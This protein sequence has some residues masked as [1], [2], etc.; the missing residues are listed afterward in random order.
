MLS[1]AAARCSGAAASCIAAVVMMPV[2]SGFVRKRAS[3]GCARPLSKASGCTRPSTQRPYFGS[4]SRIV[5]PPAMIPPLRSLCPR[6]R[7]GWRRSSPAACPPG[8]QRRSARAD[9]AAHRVD[10]AHRVGGGDRAIVVRVVYQRREEVRRHHDR[11]L[12]VQAVDGGVV[13]R[14]EADQQVGR[15]W[16]RVPRGSAG[17]AL[18]LPR[19][20]YRLSRR[21]RRA[22]SNERAPW[23][24]VSFRPQ[25]NAEVRP[26]AV[27][28]I[29]LLVAAL[30]VACAA[31][32]GRGGG[33]DVLIGVLPTPA[34]GASPTSAVAGAS[35]RRSRRCRRARRRWSRWPGSTRAPRA[36]SF[37]QPS[38]RLPT[39]RAEGGHRGRA[40]WS[41]GLVLG[42]RAQPGERALR[43]DQRGQSLLR[44]EP[45]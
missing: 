25:Y 19:L 11:L 10:V 18:W 22:R 1:T 37:R 5:W 40:G 44:R 13:G 23:P 4:S 29:L 43:G 2:P 32:D 31:A 38:R 12:V 15:C 16:P 17:P 20:L 36:P 28:S 41:R 3:P 39:T 7:A 30:V 42:R 9:L 6:R 14:G 8:R 21:R 45:L 24:R 27:G 33:P 26:E 34:Q 35:P